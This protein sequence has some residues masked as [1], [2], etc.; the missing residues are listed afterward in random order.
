MIKLYKSNMN[1][2]LCGVCGGIG[3]YFNVDPTIVRLIF[4]ILGLWSGSGVILYII[5]SL[6]IPEEGI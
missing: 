4:V 2:K 5:A 1:K 6:L 3:E